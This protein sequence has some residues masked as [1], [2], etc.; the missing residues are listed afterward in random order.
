MA[1][2]NRRFSGAWASAAPP[3]HGLLGTLIIKATA[4]NPGGTIALSRVAG[5]ILAYLSKHPNA[6]DTLEGI[7]HWWLLEQRIKRVIAEVKAALASLL[8]EKLV[9]SRRGG[10]GQTRYRLNRRKAAQIRTRVNQ[11]ND[12]PA[13]AREPMEKD[14]LTREQ[15]D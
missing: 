15:S 10:D 6:E 13:K 1:P 14:S 5:E 3:A 8:T 2:Q 11:A 9:L 4:T 7:V 12:H